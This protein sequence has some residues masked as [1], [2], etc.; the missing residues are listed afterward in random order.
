M[1]LD[2]IIPTVPFLLE[3]NFSGSSS[4]GFPQRTSFSRLRHHHISSYVHVLKNVRTTQ[5]LGGCV[6]RE[7][8]SF[9][10]EKRV[11]LIEDLVDA[12]PSYA[13]RRSFISFDEDIPYMG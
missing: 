5:E 8:D 3:E 1:A 10:S 2:V 7:C 4:S 12:L 9:S 13:L 6:S 11:T